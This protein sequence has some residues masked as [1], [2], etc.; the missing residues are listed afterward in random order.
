M[1][2][3]P[4]FTDPVVANDSMR[5]ANRKGRAIIKERQIVT[6]DLDKMFCVTYND[7]AHT[8]RYTRCPKRYKAL[9]LEKMI[10]AAKKLTSV[11]PTPAKQLVNLMLKT[12][13]DVIL[14]K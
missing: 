14:S 12:H 1:K 4:K 3:T 10:E 11:S 5:E 7:N 9:L 2:K 13:P 6:P 8:K